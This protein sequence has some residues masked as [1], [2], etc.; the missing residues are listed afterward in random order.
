MWWCDML[1]RVRTRVNKNGGAECDGC[2]VGTTRHGNVDR[3]LFSLSPPEVPG[4]REVKG[5]PK[6]D[7]LIRW[8]ASPR[9]GR[10]R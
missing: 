7:F 10:V 3:L 9:S 1:G 8:S 2:H 5:V 4:R 6:W